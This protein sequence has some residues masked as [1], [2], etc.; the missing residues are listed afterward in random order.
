MGAGRDLRNR[1]GIKRCER[2]DNLG[3]GFLTVD[4]L[5]N[6]KSDGIKVDDPLGCQQDS[7]AA[8]RIIMHPH[9]ARYPWYCLTV[10]RRHD[11]GVKTYEPGTQAPGGIR[12]GVT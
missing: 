1:C 2:L 11:A 5:Q 6:G 9:A 7:F 10:E 4:L 8:Y 3:H 12:A